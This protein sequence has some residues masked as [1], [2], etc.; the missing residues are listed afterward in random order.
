MREIYR[1]FHVNKISLYIASA[2]HTR[3]LFLRQ[4][5]KCTILC[6]YQLLL[7][8]FFQSTATSIVEMIVAS[9]L[10]AVLIAQR[11]LFVSAQE[12]ALVPTAGSLANNS[13]YSCD[14]A[15]CI[16]PTCF[17]ASKDPP[18]GL[19]PSNVPQFVTV[20]FD[21]GIQPQLL[22]TAYKMLNI[23]YVYSACK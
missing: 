16:P 10:A 5:Q 3:E 21:D 14:P 1:K 4:Y 9:L 15:K 11:G 7:L 19:S 12:G 17:C 2:R 13:P 8:G 23:K 20:T 6:S 18:G 22:E